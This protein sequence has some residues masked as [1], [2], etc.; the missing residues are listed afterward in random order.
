MK[1]ILEKGNANAKI[2]TDET[3]TM[4]RKAMKVNWE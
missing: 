2:K 3:M 4:V 1:E